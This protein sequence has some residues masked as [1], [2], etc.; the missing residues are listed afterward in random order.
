M[1]FNLPFAQEIIEDEHNGLL[2]RAHDVKDFADKIRLLLSD[3][4]LRW[5]LGRNA[6]D[7][8]KR[9]HNWDIQINEHLKVYTSVME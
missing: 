6:Y 8:V 2:A 5:K 1:A 9:E 4:K 3:K 7:Y